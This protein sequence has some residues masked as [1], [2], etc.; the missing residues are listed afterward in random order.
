[1]KSSCDPFMPVAGGTFQRSAPYS[2]CSGG[3]GG[4]GRG[5][6]GAIVSN[7]SGVPNTGGGGGGGGYYGQSVGGGGSGVALISYFPPMPQSES[8]SVK[9]VW[10]MLR[11]GCAAAA[12]NYCPSGSST[13]AG[14]GQ[15]TNNNNNNNNHNHNHNH[16]HSH[17]HSH[18]HNSVCSACPA[19][20][21]CTGGATQPTVC[22]QGTFSDVGASVCSGAL[23]SRS[24]HLMSAFRSLHRLLH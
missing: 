13:S 9:C 1:M 17:S 7:A 21:Y 19:G 11:E 14:V 18:S 16:N 2:G 8:A 20:S 3:L 24:R 5:V 15:S 4:G 10:L 12:G 6:T 23:A 22:P